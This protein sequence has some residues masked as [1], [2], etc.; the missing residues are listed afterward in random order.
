MV[1]LTRPNLGVGG[2]APLAPAF[3]STGPMPQ[4]NV[5]PMGKTLNAGRRGIEAAMNTPCFQKYEAAGKT[6][7]CSHC[8]S[9]LFEP[10]GIAGFSA[11]GY[12]IACSRCT[13]AQY[14][15]KRPIAL[16]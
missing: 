2:P 12:G 14:F 13:H 1:R 6:I 11:A 10:V 5:P 3:Y 16:D 8:G 9:V 15:L 4:P 7:A